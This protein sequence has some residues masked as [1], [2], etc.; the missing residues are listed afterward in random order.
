MA[1]GK[2]AGNVKGFFSDVMPLSGSE[3]FMGSPLS[4]SELDGGNYHGRCPAEPAGGVRDPAAIRPPGL[5]AACYGRPIPWR[6]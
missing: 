2:A 6:V 4:L 5:S 1:W 3:D